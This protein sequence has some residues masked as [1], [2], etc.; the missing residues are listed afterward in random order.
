MICRYD[1]KY[2]SEFVKRERISGINKKECHYSQYFIHS[3]QFRSK[4]HT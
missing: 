1:E 2:H 4:L 3:K